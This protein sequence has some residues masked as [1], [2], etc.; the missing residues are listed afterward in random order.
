MS[1]ELSLDVSLG[2]SQC[3]DGFPSQC[4]AELHGLLHNLLATVPVHIQW[5]RGLMRSR[6]LLGGTLLLLSS[7]GCYHAI[8]E[9]GAPTSTE[10][11]SQPWAS[12]WIYGLVPPK[13]IS[14]ASHCK[15]G[16]A[17]VE[18][19]LSFVNQLVSIVTLGIY[20][21]MHIQVTCAASHAQIPDA[22]PRRFAMQAGSAQSD[23]ETVFSAAATAAVTSGTPAYVVFSYNASP[24]NW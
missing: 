21:P 24:A 14:A 9:T 22:G 13:P 19:Q 8:I 20:T 11:I 16:V 23:Y 18:T 10:M 15:S 4:L 2:H 6:A 1:L 17:R 7:A 3:R 5:R 12:G